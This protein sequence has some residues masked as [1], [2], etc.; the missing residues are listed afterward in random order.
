MYETLEIETRER[1]ATVWMNR[2]RAHNAFDETLIAELTQAC[3]QLGGDAALRVV[4]LAGR[5][6]SFSAGADLDWMRRAAGYD[7]DGNRR[8]A[9]ALAAMYRAIHGL[10]KP[11]IAR[12][13]GAALGGGAGLTAVCDIAIASTEASFGTT[14]VKL[15]I[16]PAVI[17][18]YVIAAIGPRRAQRFFLTGE[19]FGAEEAHRA[20]LVHM[21]CAPDALDAAVAQLA[22]ALCANGPQA[23]AAAKALVQRVAGQP[24]D[25]AL[26]AETVERIAAV[27]AT[28]EAQEGIGAFL[29]K[30]KPRWQD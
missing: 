1:V 10:P 4:V 24:L 2:P 7:A 26:I 8:D 28:P 3:A 23:L 19:R 13:H 18:P 21:V 20:G 15:G 11:T 14:E 29:E 27:R 22:R 30:R 9:R 25:D 6:R 16:I 17:S 12:V 5:G